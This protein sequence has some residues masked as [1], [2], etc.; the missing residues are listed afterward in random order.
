MKL[1]PGKLVEERE[2]LGLSQA[3]LAERVGVHVATIAR[4]EQNHGCHPATARGIAGALGVEVR[5]LYAGPSRKR[6]ALA[7]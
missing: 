5:D 2:A 1:D 6:A 7:S 3:D 4:V